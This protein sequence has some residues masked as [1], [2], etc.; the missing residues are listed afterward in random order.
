MEFEDLRREVETI[1]LSMEEGEKDILD[2]SNDKFKLARNVL[3]QYDNKYFFATGQYAK[4][5]NRHLEDRENTAIG[6]TIPVQY[7]RWKETGILPIVMSVLQQ[8][9]DKDV[10]RGSNSADIVIKIKN[11]LR[12]NNINEQVSQRIA[13]EV[14]NAIENSKYY[15]EKIIGMNYSTNKLL[16][17]FSYEMRRVASLVRPEE[18][19]E[20]LNADE[21]KMLAKIEEVIARYQRRDNLS[22]DAFEK[23]D[24]ESGRLIKTAR[25]A[26]I[27]EI[28]V[29]VDVKKAVRENK[30]KQEE[31]EREGN[32]KKR[33]EDY[34]I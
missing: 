30:D 7:K 5:Y 2:C 11:E 31:D 25:E 24:D 27:D 3:E 23:I 34:F 22:Q 32:H 20:I 17:D 16:G 19:E 1:I 21:H 8:Y 9:R 10:M 18:I 13:W 14:E 26:F 29:D 28:H 15:S 6:K 12:A 4:L 33:A